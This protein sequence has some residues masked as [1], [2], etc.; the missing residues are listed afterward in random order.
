MGVISAMRSLKESHLVHDLIVLAKKGNIYQK[1]NF[2]R[3]AS[4]IPDDANIYYE[5]GKLIIHHKSKRADARPNRFVLIFLSKLIVIDGLLLQF[6]QNIC[7]IQL[8][9]GRFSF[10]VVK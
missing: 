8:L 1:L 10:I 3:N 4:D 9:T 6:G 5:N 2:K 7:K